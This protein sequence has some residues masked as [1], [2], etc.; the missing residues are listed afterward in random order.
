MKI[1]ELKTWPEYFKTVVDGRKTFELR[2]NDR[3]FRT[4]DRLILREWD[5]ETGE[6]TGDSIHADVTY[7]IDKGPWLTPG[8]CCMG[9]KTL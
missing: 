5:P 3:G 2:K 1:H 4:M 7:V 6:Y 8:Y 9:I